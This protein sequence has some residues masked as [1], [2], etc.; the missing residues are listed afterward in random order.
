MLAWFARGLFQLVVRL[1]FTLAACVTLQQLIHEEGYRVELQTLLLASAVAIVA[2]RLWMPW[3][4]EARS[5][6]E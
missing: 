2:I 3:S 4:R 5:S 6:G 1:G